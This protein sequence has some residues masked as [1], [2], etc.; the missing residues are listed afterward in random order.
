MNTIKNFMNDTP[1][2]WRVVRNVCIIAG[3]VLAWFV[4]APEVYQF[5][6]PDWLD[7][8]LKMSNGF[9]GLLALIA[10]SQGIPEDK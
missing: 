5:A 10:Q 9:V 1:K 3:M 4:A 7:L 2:G 8:A 6:Y